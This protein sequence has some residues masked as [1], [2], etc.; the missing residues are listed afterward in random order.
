M[1]E[2]VAYDPSWPQRFAI[3][4]RRLQEAFGARARRVEHVVSTAVPGLAAKPVIDIQISVDS[5]APLAPLAD[6]LA[7][8][9][10]THVPDPDAAFER[11]YPFF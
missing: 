8:L 2:L 3:E 7:A 5:L 9:G 11:V 4:A 1:I 10:Y 6:V